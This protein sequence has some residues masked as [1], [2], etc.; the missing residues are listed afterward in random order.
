MSNLTQLTPE[1]QAERSALARLLVALK[2][3]GRDLSPKDRQRKNILTRRW[4]LAEH[5]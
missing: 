2:K 4:M 3:Q 1:E 5:E